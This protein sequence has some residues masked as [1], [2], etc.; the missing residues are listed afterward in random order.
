MCVGDNPLISA[1]HFICEGQQAKK[2]LI[3]PGSTGISAP[4]RAA[5]GEARSR[6]RLPALAALAHHEAPDRPGGITPM[7]DP[8][9]RRTCRPTSSARCCARC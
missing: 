6:F 1:A 2:S 3:I 5:G 7:I 9:S 4:N 8:T